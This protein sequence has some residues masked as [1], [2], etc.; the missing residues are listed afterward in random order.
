MSVFVS[1]THPVVWFFGDK[2][3]NLSP[4]A[5]A[6]F[7]SAA[8]GN[9]FIYI[10]AVALWETAILERKGRIKLK[11]GFTRWTETILKNSGFGIAPFSM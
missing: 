11:D 2:H 10:P 9:G 1:D 5:L 6:A 7:Q 3:Q 8:S 4:K